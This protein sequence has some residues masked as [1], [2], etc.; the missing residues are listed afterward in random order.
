MQKLVDGVHRFHERVF[1]PQRE[2]YE[3]LV[4]GQNPDTLFIT[5]ADSRISAEL[6]TQSK[7]GEL[8][9]LRNAG[10]IVP[11]HSVF[12]GGEAATIEYAVS[13]L[14][15]TDIVICGHSHCGAM[16]GL[17]APA[18]LVDLPHVAQWLSH[19]EATRLI[20]KA[21]YADLTGQELL[22]ATIE[23]NVLVQLENLETHPAVRL[24]LLTGRVKVHGWVYRF[25]TGEV[26]VYD[27]T[28]GQFVHSCEWSAGSRTAAKG[29]P[30][31]PSTA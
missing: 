8:F 4:D 23:E 5:C 6:V 29:D 18:T 3:R 10:N 30:R 22:D 13:A 21:R 2:L 19:A 15:V 20:I 1:R 11:T 26:Y 17:I 25:E 31:G 12:N 28:A 14:G 27:P 16:A 9:V 24:G 7:P